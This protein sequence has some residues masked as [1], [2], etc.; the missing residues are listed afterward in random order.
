MGNKQITIKIADICI[1]IKLLNEDFYEL[2]SYYET[3]DDADFVLAATESDLEEERNQIATYTEEGYYS[4]TDVERLWLLRQIAEKVPEYDA[5]LIHGASFRVDEDAYLLL[6]PSGAGK[7]TQSKLW[8]KYFG[9][10]MRMINDDKPILRMLGDSIIVGASPWCGKE[11]WNNNITAPL[12]GIVSIN[13]AKDNK[14][15]PVS[16]QTAWDLVMNQVHRSKNPKTMQKIMR[17]ID[18]MIE[19]TPVYRLEC[20]REFEAVR[21]AYDALSKRG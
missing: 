9:E 17:M 7:T 2:C 14:I 21:I 11:N 15:E 8:K 20:N 12:K 4:D 16:S 19:T 5:F 10:R 13:Q 18:S 3:N 1:G 6:G